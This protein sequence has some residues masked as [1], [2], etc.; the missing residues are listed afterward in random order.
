VPKIT[1]RDAQGEE[2]LDADLSGE[3][4]LGRYLRSAA[5]LRSV[6]P[7]ARS[8]SKPLTDS[9]GGELALTTDHDVPVGK[10]GELTISGGASVA[11]GVH[12]SGGTMLAGSDLQAPITVPN[13]T[14][15]TSLTL[16]AL[17]K[18]GLAGSKD[19]IGF[20]F[21]AGTALR[22]AY[23]HPFDVVGNSLTLRDAVKKMV[24]AA[25]FPADVDDLNR[26]SD[27]T[28][29][30]L[31]GE[32]ELSFSG[33]AVLSSTTNLLATPGLPLIGTVSLTQGASV[34][35]NATWTVSGEFELRV[36]KL[37]A[38]Q[39]RL[40]FYRRRGRSLSVSAKAQAGVTVN[41]R[42]SDLIATLMRAISSDPEADLLALVN[43]GLEDE[44]ILAIQ[45]A[46]EESIDRSLTLSAQ[47]QISALREAEA[48]FA[49]DIE[50]PRL[51][52]RV[53]SA[54]DEALHGRLGPLSE[55]VA[56]AGAPVRLIA[57]AAK[58]LRERKTTWRINVLGILNVASFAELVR[59]GTL[60]F[61]PV[62]GAL[63]A[64]DKVSAR[65][66]RIT[67]RPL[68]SDAGKLRKVLFESLMVTAAY[69]ASRALGSAVS[70]T[71][72]HLYLEQRGRTKRADLE[73]HYRA[74]IALGLG[75]EAERDARL[76]TETEFGGSTF[77]IEN[78]LNPAACDAMFLDADGEPHDMEPYEDI[79]RRALLALVPADD[80]ARSYRRLAL[81]S[82]TIWAQVRNLGGDIDRAL[83]GHIRHDPLRLGVVR[84]DVFTVVWWARA[85]SKAA[86]ELVA[87]RKFLG[88]RNATALAADP[89]FRK[90]KTKL[91][92]ALAGVVATTEARFDDP[93]DVLAMDDAAARLGRLDAV[94][95]STRFAVR[96]T[97]P[98]LAPAPAEAPPVSRAARTRGARAPRLGSGQTLR[99]RSGQARGG[100]E[101]RDWTAEE[102]DVFSRHV[103]N[104][105]E[106][107]LS[108]EGSFRSSREQ[109]ERIFGELIPAYAKEQKALGR[110]PRVF[111]YAHGGLTEERN[112]LRPVLGRRRF[113]E[114]NNVY[115]VYF[116]WETGLRETLLDIVGGAI[117][118]SRATARG[119]VTDFAIER[120]AR[121]GGKQVWGQMKKSAEKSA[122]ADGGAR[123]VASLAGGLWKKL[124][125]EIEFHALGHSAGAIFHAHFLPQLVAER[126]SGVPPVEVRTLH[127]LAPAI[128]TGL[129]KKNLLDL[130][131]SGKPITGLTMYTMTDELEQADDAG[132]YSKSLLYLVSRSFE[133]DVPTPILG[134][135]EA[136]KRDLQLIRFFGLA[137]TQKVAD[138]VFSKSSISAALRDRSES[139][140]HGGFDNDIATMTS[141]IRRVLDLPETSEAIE[142]FEEA[143]PGFDKP[144]IGVPRAEA[145]P[146]APAP[147]A[148]T[149]VRRAPA[150]R[151]APARKKWTVMVWMAGDNDLES[152]G[153]KDL[154]EMKRVGSTS[155]IN[156][157]VQF[158]S[159]RDDRTRRYSVT[160]GGQ[161]D[162]DVVEELGETNTGDPVVAIDFFRWAIERYP[163]ERLLGV[164]WNHGSGIDETDIY[165][166]AGARGM[167]VVRGVA[168]GPGDV[169]RNLVRRA[170]S[171]RHRRALF[172]TTVSEAT[173]DR[174]IAYD[175]TSRD[176][177]DN[178][179]LKKV[180]AEVK[181]QTGRV[182]DVLGF[183]ACLMNMIEV[184]YQLKGTA[185]VV[186]GSEELEPGDGWPYDRVLGSLAANPDMSDADLSTQIVDQYIDSYRAGSITQSA[187][188]LSRLDEVAREVNALA[189]ALIK[190]IRSAAEYTA[191]TKSLNATQRFDT[192]DF[193]DLGHFCKELGK[194]SKAAA[195]KK[196][197]KA[198]LDALTGRDGFVLA[199]RHK[200]SDVSDA[201]GA[202][203]YFP[204]GPV[205][206]VYGRLDFAKGTGW[207]RFL[208][209]YHKA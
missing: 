134:M 58:Q 142:Y 72:E 63:T 2:L 68:E 38:S 121:N 172:A 199:E 28:H 49:Y 135:Q 99:L 101:P 94:I 113:W 47:L 159:M 149:A 24:S 178:I 79:G 29:V 147:A 189:A 9:G 110:R 34:T 206:K 131:G 138:A 122:G 123:L 12:P 5:S 33:E 129:F 88:A 169:Q 162:E 124:R 185:R 73:D 80:P 1:I 193:V 67:S 64:A 203:I 98:E 54:V 194:R 130:V 91:S 71:A 51:N 8:F 141:M 31:A 16:E 156:V 78:H 204:R 70:L 3:G 55:V 36:S 207:R 30:S 179:E 7:L 61:D 195:V 13:G 202:A 19:H 120:L 208:D 96:Y 200:G 77:V 186:V 146:A 117:R 14:T 83:P 74:L 132:P 133:D 44:P 151:A 196:T 100:S 50:L 39:A 136:L 60:M 17:L 105:R 128:T 15:Y 140:T 108:G 35:V 139:M 125:G 157:T 86:A 85:M 161:L 126:T 118:P 163:A 103:V 209:A 69:Q 119:A 46:I 25:V 183:D 188:N 59:E 144:A 20:G 97:E 160:K 205:S 181:K 158:D 180:L 66:I 26:L 95:V 92:D 176:F 175:D 112:G 42:D 89:A 4:G 187:L 43:A 18:A 22:Y 114:L 90:A 23:F 198:V 143:V 40:A 184:A 150:V 190:A 82:D 11:I 154:A 87:M 37:S 177:L 171:S 201:T 173:Q 102:R 48:L 116:V 165:A 27:G 164:I 75:D 84:G 145:R 52:A 192:A 62:S 174:A 93:W 137:G 104:L 127:L 166:R 45:R 10:N 81:A 21:E 65:R 109:V 148:S 191:V 57:S 56:A 155:D 167:S 170:L 76:G 115:P 32:G 107:K 152:F 168:A 197:T 6:V 182:L 41:I 106:G 153:D 53:K 111:F